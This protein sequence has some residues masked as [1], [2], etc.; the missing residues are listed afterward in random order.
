MGGRPGS[1]EARD[2]G[3]PHLDAHRSPGSPFHH[4]VVTVETQRRPAGNTESKGNKETLT[5]YDKALTTD[6]DEML[7]LLTAYSFHRYFGDKIQTVFSEEDFRL[8]R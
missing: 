8:Y 4:V 1:R 7:Q 3:S 5:C 6:V 2:A